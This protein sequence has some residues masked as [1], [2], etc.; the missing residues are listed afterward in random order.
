MSAAPPPLMRPQP[1]TP[2]G[3][4][5]SAQQ[6]FTGSCAARGRSGL[7]L[8]VATQQGGGHHNDVSKHVAFTQMVGCCEG[9]IGQSKR[10]GTPKVVHLKVEE[11]EYRSPIGRVHAQ[12]CGPPWSGVVGASC[13]TTAETDKRRMARR[14]ARRL[15]SSAATAAT[16]RRQF[17]PHDSVIFMPT[18]VHKPA[19]TVLFFHGLG[20]TGYGGLS[21]LVEHH[22][23][24]LLPATKFVLPTAPQRPVTLNGG[25]VMPA[26]V[27]VAV[28]FHCPRAC[29]PCCASAWAEVFVR[30]R[31]R[32][33]CTASAVVVRV[34]YEAVL[35]IPPCM[36]CHGGSC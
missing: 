29:Q 31:S 8:P 27:R 30:R 5:V 4:T 1:W 14:M 16:H 6:T 13:P 35:C 23:G 17:G 25:M 36:Y 33:V 24:P 26:W 10:H 18:S 12:G 7:N 28:C 2:P 22:W 34:L 32:S 11:Q 15:L 21:D 20:D 19:S 3:C 9:S